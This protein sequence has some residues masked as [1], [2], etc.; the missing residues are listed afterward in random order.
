VN[1]VSGDTITVNLPPGLFSKAVSG[2]DAAA[3]GSSLSHATPKTDD[4]YIL[5]VGSNGINAG[6]ITITITGLA[7]NDSAK[8]SSTK[9]VTAFTS[10]E[11]NPSALG[12]ISGVM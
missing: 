12:V 11:S 2:T 10:K 7:L 4:K 5:T 3:T 9:I 1:L 6:S 8:F